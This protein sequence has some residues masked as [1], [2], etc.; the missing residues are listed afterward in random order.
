LILDS[1]ALVAIILREPERDGFLAKVDRAKDV[2]AGA[3]SL[4]E[5]G[6]VLS[7]R[8]RQDAGPLLAEIL[9]SMGVSVVEFRDEHWR[10]AVSAWYRFGK[11][12]H[13]AAL[14][15]GDCL[16]YA[17]AKVAGQPVLAKGDDFA[18]TDLAV[19]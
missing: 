18:K 2:A 16:T 8:S 7:S 15:L 11:G 4:V 12:R 17:V 10:A 1:S 9:Q 13:P 19:A 3:P 5:T 14:N 6:M